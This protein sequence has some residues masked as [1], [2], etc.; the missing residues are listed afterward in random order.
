MSK[1]K[2]KKLFEKVPSKEFW[3]EHPLENSFAI[4]WCK[5]SFLNDSF[6]KIYRTLNSSKNFAEIRAAC[7]TLVKFGNWFKDLYDLNDHVEVAIN[8]LNS[9]LEQDESFVDWEEKRSLQ[10]AIKNQI[11][12][13]EYL[14]KDMS[15]AI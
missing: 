13:L 8:K 5:A 12:D 3:G 7:F 10:I 14:K 1:E 15:R 11:N 6:A 9:L 4:E 2:K